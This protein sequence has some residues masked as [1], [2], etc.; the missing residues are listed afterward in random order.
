MKADPKTRA[1]AKRLRRELTDAERILW[2]R[3]KERQLRGWLFRCQHPVGPYIL[4]FA[5]AKLRLAVEIDGATH[6]TLPE[7]LHDERR[8]RYLAARGWFTVRFWNDEVYRNLHGVV[9]SI[10]ERLPPR[11][12]RALRARRVKRAGPLRHS[13]S[14]NAT[15]PS[16]VA[17]GGGNTER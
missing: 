11:E 1:R 10:L 13:A 16:R 14:P 15:S 8:A 4:D 9:E 7:R 17:T 12:A 2:S 5:C 6:S 3:I